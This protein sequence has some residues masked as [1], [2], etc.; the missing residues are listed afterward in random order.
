MVEIGNAFDKATNTPCPVCLKLAKKGMIPPRTVMPLPEFPARRR[1]TDEPCCVDCQAADTVMA[2][3]G[4]P[5][6]EGAR[7][8]TASERLE[9]LLLPKGMMERFGLCQMGLLKPC[10]VEDLANH[11]VFLELNELPNAAC[12]HPE[13]EWDNFANA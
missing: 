3:G 13:E 12:C 9:G 10:S 6:F 11:L 5:M 2:I 1:E 4:H 8:A 7:V